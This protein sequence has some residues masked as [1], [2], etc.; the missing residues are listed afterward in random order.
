[1]VR[2]AFV[3][4]NPSYMPTP[5]TGEQDNK[6]GTGTPPGDNK[7]GNNGSSDAGKSGEDVQRAI[8]AIIA[9]ERGDAATALAA[10]DRELADLKA[11]LDGKVDP[12]DEKYAESIRKPLVDELDKIRARETKRE[13]RIKGSEIRAAAKDLVV[14]GADE[15]VANALMANLKLTEDDKLEVVD[16]D[17][18]PRYGAKGPMTLGELVTEH[19]S[20]KPYLAKASVRSGLG[21][22]D[23]PKG[24]SSSANAK[25]ADLRQQIAEAEGKKEF[26]KAGRLKGELLELLRKK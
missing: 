17:G 22:K 25:E 21:L 7:G 9:R 19:L 5:G 15:D 2:G 24:G 11:K 16:A 14:D 8:N 26:A 18:R 12:K 10:K 1:M 20:G 4:P 23:V 6:D 3:F 13:A